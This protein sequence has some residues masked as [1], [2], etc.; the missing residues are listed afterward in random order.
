MFCG[1]K[2]MIKNEQYGLRVPV[3]KGKMKYNL[4]HERVTLSEQSI[5]Q[6]N[7]FSFL[8]L[9]KLFHF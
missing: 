3:Y 9:I 2:M 1:K 6:K 8:F 5:A 4:N 7:N